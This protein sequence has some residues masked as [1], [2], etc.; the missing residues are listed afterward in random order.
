M[1]M[2]AKNFSML[3][4]ILYWITSSLAM[5]VFYYNNFLLPELAS[6]TGKTIIEL[7]FLAII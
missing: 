1:F 2:A 4:L 5:E 7:I 3:V 6:N